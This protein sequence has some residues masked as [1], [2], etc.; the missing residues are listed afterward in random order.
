MAAYTGPESEDGSATMTAAYEM[1]E[2]GIILEVGQRGVAAE[3]AA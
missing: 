1:A 2:L 3:R